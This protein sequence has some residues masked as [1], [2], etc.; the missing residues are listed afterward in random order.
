LRP[1]MALAFRGRASNFK[2]LDL[3]LAG[4]IK[5][6]GIVVPSSFEL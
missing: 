6:Y 4:K 2:D 3:G 1:G 5:K